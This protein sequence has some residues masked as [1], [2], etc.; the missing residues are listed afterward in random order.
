MPQSTPIDSGTIR[1]REIYRHYTM[2][3]SVIRAVDGITFAARGENSL[4]CWEFRARE[5]PRC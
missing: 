5:N 3:A 4:P 2:G 1:T